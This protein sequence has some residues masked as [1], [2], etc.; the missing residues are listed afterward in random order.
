[1]ADDNFGDTHEYAGTPGILTG[2]ISVASAGAYSK[3]GMGW[4]VLMG[5]GIGATSL[6][7]LVSAF[8][9]WGHYTICERISAFV[10]FVIGELLMTIRS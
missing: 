7:G 6:A 10:V 9:G 2:I 3:A 8:M 4:S 1:M 5:A